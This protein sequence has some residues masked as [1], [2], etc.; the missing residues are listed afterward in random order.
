VEG[1]RLSH[2]TLLTKIGEGGMGAV[3]RATDSRLNRTVAIKVLPPHA[4]AS[5]DRQR[6]FVQEAQ[7][8]S[9]LNHPN[10]VHIYDIDSADGVT[11]IAMEFVDGRA[12]DAVIAEAQIPI[13]LVLDYAVQASGALAA[14]HDQGDDAGPHAERALRLRRAG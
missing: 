10:I 9:G 13:A 2:Y 11:F 14:A 1:Q 12:L 7:S 6:R 4:S 3:Y 8:A 5:P